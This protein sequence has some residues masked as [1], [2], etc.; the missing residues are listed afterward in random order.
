ML[1]LCLKLVLLALFLLCLSMFKSNAT[2]RRMFIMALCSSSVCHAVTP[3]I[4]FDKADGAL[5]DIDTNG[6]LFG[7]R[8]D[9]NLAEDPYSLFDVEPDLTTIEAASRLKKNKFLY[10]PKRD[11]W[12]NLHNVNNNEKLSHMVTRFDSGIGY[13]NSRLDYFFRDWRENK[14]IAMDSEVLK[15]LFGICEEMLGNKDSINVQI[16]SGYRTH[17]TN[18]KLRV[19]SKNV[20]KNSFHIEGK[21]IDFAIGDVSQNKLRSAARDICSGGL[22]LYQ[23][24]IHIDSG[25]LRRWG[26]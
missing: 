12:I 19:H 24:F 1:C 21:A 9:F 17:K 10:K 16:T 8:K 20:A 6:S 26:V 7:S 11:F 2:S 23:G 14:S 22:G 3:L 4:N 5:I 13:Y 18:E 25:P 15:N